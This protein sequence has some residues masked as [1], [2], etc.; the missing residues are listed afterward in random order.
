MAD[1]AMRPAQDDEIDLR[2]LISTLWRWKLLILSV[3]VA[4]VLA[5]AMYAMLKK[6]VY[7]ASF[8]VMPGAFQDSTGIL[9]PIDQYNQL[10]AFV[11]GVPLWERRVWLESV[12]SSKGS[13]KI[14]IVLRGFDPVLLREKADG[15]TGALKTEQDR[16]LEVRLLPVRKQ[17]ETAARQMALYEAESVR[18]HRALS[19]VQKAQ[20]GRH[21]P[22]LLVESNR[23][24]ERLLTLEIERL[25]LEAES[26]QYQNPVY[27]PS[28]VSTVAGGNQPVAPKK[29]L[30]VAVAFVA[31]LMGSIFLVFFIEFVKGFKQEEK[32]A[33]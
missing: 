21:E 26:A 10:S 33:L 23:M 16:L 24:Q 29:K 30:I 31:G 27:F 20:A 14:D 22:L 12:A 13:S 9:R 3:T 6:P 5:A 4:S 8:S 1:T 2:E 18:L 7:E 11:E 32:P 17:A 15:L 25:K 28:R 19:E